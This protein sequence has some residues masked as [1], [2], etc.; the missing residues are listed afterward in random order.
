MY[1]AWSIPSER[2]ASRKVYLS[3]KTTMKDQEDKRPHE[4]DNGALTG[5][6]YKTTIAYGQLCRWCYKLFGTICRRQTQFEMLL[7]GCQ[8]VNGIKV[9]MMKN[10]KTISQIIM[11]SFGRLFRYSAIYGMY[12]LL[13]VAL[14]KQWKTGASPKVAF[15]FNGYYSI[16]KQIFDL[17]ASIQ[18]T[19]PNLFCTRINFEIRNHVE[20][21]ENR[22]ARQ[23]CIAREDVTTL[24][25]QNIIQEGAPGDVFLNDG[26]KELTKVRNV[27]ADEIN[28]MK[29]SDSKSIEVKKGLE[30]RPLNPILSQ[31]RTFNTQSLTPPRKQTWV[32]KSASS[33]RKDDKLC[34][35]FGSKHS[36]FDDLAAGLRKR[37]A[38]LSTA[39]FKTKV[40]LLNRGVYDD[41]DSENDGDGGRWSTG[42]DESDSLTGSTRETAC[43]KAILE[44]LNDRKEQKQS[45]V[46]TPDLLNT[47]SS[48][49]HVIKNKI[50][51]NSVVHEPSKL[52]HVNSEPM[53]DSNR[54]RVSNITKNIENNVDG[55]SSEKPY[56]QKE[57][58]G[59]ENKFSPNIMQNATMKARNED[60]IRVDERLSVQ[61]E[62]LHMLSPRHS[63]RRS[64]SR[65]RIIYVPSSSEGVNGVEGCDE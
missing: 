50:R 52:K 4:D 45:R 13:R 65:R 9:L 24:S 39:V 11:L 25:K 17:K 38:R 35:P 33:S 63:R 28:L 43:N 54:L 49:V 16:L 21:I 6:S 19:L 60:D 56:N 18:L 46:T 57:N 58:E 8:W 5:F 7:L 26:G 32:K 36:M 40:A 42:T 12:Y 10:T 64:R 29:N 15:D 3:P 23:E 20:E 41:D 30:S 34:S 22:N 47:L 1:N 51:L 27:D 61:S 62:K 44:N 31:I 53:A 55:K 2:S 48:P 59:D 37:R 14:V